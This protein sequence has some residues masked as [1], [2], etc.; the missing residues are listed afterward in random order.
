[1]NKSFRYPKKKGTPSNSH[2]SRIS[3][4][5]SGSNAS[6]TIEKKLSLRQ[7]EMLEQNKNLKLKDP[8]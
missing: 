4:H 6:Q 1:M 5:K 3:S 8:E 7:E 2:R